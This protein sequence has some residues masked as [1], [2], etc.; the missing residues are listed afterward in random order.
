MD[1]GVAE[2][3]PENAVLD[4]VER[5]FPSAHR[6]QLPA[7]GTVR[8]QTRRD[9]DV[10]DGRDRIMLDHDLHGQGIVEIDPESEGLVPGQ[11]FGIDGLQRGDIGLERRPVLRARLE[12]AIVETVRGA[13][14][15]FGQP[16]LQEAAPGG[17]IRRLQRVSSGR[18][19]DNAQIEQKEYKH[20]GQTEGGRVVKGICH[21]VRT[22]RA[23]GGGGRTLH[24]FVR[25]VQAR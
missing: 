9:I 20:P 14:L 19:N 17:M 25:Q 2:F 7:P 13:A 4:V 16:G 12:A 3:G 21:G 6:H 22:I 18:W 15:P 5:E 24:R 23:I 1:A 11:G 8:E 10:A